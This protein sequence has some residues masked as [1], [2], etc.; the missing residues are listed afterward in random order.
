MA[1]LMD[2][3]EANRLLK[4]Y[5]ISAV[6]SSYVKSPTDAISFF[7]YVKSPIVMKAI[8]EKA[9]HKSRS[10]LVM[11][12][13]DTAEKARRA[14][15]E[16]SKRAAKFKPYRILAQKMLPHDVEI[17]VGGREDPQFGKIMLLGL[18]G[19]YV[20]A[21]RD[22][23]V[24]VCPITDFDA[25]DMIDQL[26]ASH[27]IAKDEQSRSMLKGVLMRVSKMLY[28]NGSIGELDLNPMVMDGKRY[29]AVDIRVLK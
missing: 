5:G 9:L 29:V 25:G 8:S 17:I 14:Y 15:D 23:A 28:N 21:F 16:L 27:I 2:Y 7:R 18:G 19:I 12:N 6:E 24:R 3:M 4:R 20:E 10:G 11:L 13:L 22:F 1:E 26:R